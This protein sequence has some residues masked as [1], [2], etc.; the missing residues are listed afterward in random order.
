M[1]AGLSNFDSDRLGSAVA[2]SMAGSIANILSMASPTTA[3]DY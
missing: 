1:W 3:T 2:V